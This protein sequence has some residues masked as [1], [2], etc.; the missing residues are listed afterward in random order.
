MV[1]AEPMIECMFPSS[2]SRLMDALYQFMV[3]ELELEAIRLK[4]QL[5]EKKRKIKLLQQMAEL[6]RRSEMAQEQ[7]ES[8]SG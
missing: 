2:N 6:E 5:E 4:R 7:A 1:S 3:R 8:H